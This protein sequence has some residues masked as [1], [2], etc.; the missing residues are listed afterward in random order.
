MEGNTFISSYGELGVSLLAG[1]V[2]AGPDA[3]TTTLSGSV[4][5]RSSFF[6]TTSTGN[7]TFTDGISHFATSLIQNI[8]ISLLSGNINYGL[9]ND[10]ATNL[11]YINSTCSSSLTVYI[12]NPARL[13][14]T[15][16]VALGVT[17][18]VTSAVVAYGWWHNGADQKLVF[19]DVIRIGLNEEMFDISGNL[20]GRTW[21]YLKRTAG[22][23]EKLI[24]SSPFDD[25]VG[26]PHT[27]T[28]EIKEHSKYEPSILPF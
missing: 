19:S 12:Y 26:N 16:G 28:I 17:L 6:A 9:S 22:S 7:H 15:Y 21:V 24:P 20:E 25:S 23:S 2:S 14:T 5:Q 8:S 13:L 10:T 3:Y 1:S 27:S 4:V 11:Q 18:L